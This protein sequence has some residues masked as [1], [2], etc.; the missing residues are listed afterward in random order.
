MYK[1][2]LVACIFV[3][4]PGKINII[5]ETEKGSLCKGIN[6]FDVNFPSDGDNND[7]VK[8]QVSGT[9]SLRHCSNADIIK[10]TYPDLHLNSNYF[11][12]GRNLN[13]F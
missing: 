10:L 5:Q 6:K 3:I 9:S 2:V 8:G 12:T 4:I 13:F 1:F 11:S 7:E